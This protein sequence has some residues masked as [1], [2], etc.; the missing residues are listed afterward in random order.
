MDVEEIVQNLVKLY[1]I[2]KVYSEYLTKKCR[3]CKRI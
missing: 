1:Q 2:S 3:S